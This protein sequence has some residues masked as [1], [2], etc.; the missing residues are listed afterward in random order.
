M[1][2]GLLHEKCGCSFP[3]LPTEGGKNN[4]SNLPWIVTAYMKLSFPAGPV[5]KNP[6]AKQDRWVQSLGWEDLLEKEMATHSCLEN[7]TDRGAWWTT[8]H[9][10]A[11]ELDA[12]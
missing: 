9:W 12:S 11:L 7:P 8:V 4:L 10:I 6:P 3:S 2:L 1:G 5:V